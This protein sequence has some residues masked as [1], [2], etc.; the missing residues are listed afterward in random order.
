LPAALVLYKVTERGELKVFEIEEGRPEIMEGSEEVLWLG[1]WGLDCNK[2]WYVT[3]IDID[4][5]TSV[6][7]L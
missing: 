3:V 4:A 2:D 6:V 1:R 7:E 5:I